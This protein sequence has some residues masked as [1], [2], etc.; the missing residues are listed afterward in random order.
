MK[1]LLFVDISNWKFITW[2]VVISFWT[3]F[4]FFKI[5]SEKTFIVDLSENVD[6][7]N[8]IYIPVIIN[9][10]V[11]NFLFDTGAS[12]NIIDF[13]LA[14]KIGL[15]IDEKIFLTISRFTKTWS[16]SISFSKKIAYIGNLKLNTTFALNGYNGLCIDD[17]E[18][19]QRVGAI[20]GIE[21]IQH[22]N[23]LFNFS[24]NN[25]TISKGK[26][27]ISSFPDDQMLNLDFFYESGIT[28]V[29]LIID[30]VSIQNIAFD[31]GY[32]KSIIPFFKERELIDIVFSKSDIETL[33][34]NNKH[35]NLGFSSEL[36]KVFVIDSVQ[37]NDFTMQGLFALEHNEINQTLITS[38]FVRRFRMM[39]FDS[40]NKKIQLYVSPSDSARHHRRNLQNF[41]RALLQHFEEN[42]NKAGDGIPQEIINLW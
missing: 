36:G 17:I 16:D 24:D 5:K 23:W 7:S 42:P 21:T 26:I 28:N 34:S 10:N 27:K 9:N 15:S 31:T 8:H 22:F 38:N 32:E 3:V 14:Q 30:G 2:G 20:M 37:I 12:F 25:V 18:L 33:A 6:K 29:D 13:G 39:Y 40:K 4:F 19:M 35:P 41:S 11:Y 1:N